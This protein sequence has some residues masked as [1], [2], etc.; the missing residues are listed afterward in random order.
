VGVSAVYIKNMNND[1]LTLEQH[2]Q[3]ECLCLLGYFAAQAG[4]AKR[5]DIIN[6]LADA[7]FAGK[8]PDLKNRKNWWTRKFGNI[9]F[10]WNANG[11]AGAMIHGYLM[12]VAAG[13]G[14]SGH[15]GVQRRI[16]GNSLRYFLEDL[17]KCVLLAQQFIDQGVS[18][19]PQI[20]E[21]LFGVVAGPGSITLSPQEQEDVDLA[22]KASPEGA[23]KLVKHYQR[24]RDAGLSRDAK[25]AFVKANGGKLFCQACGVEPL[26][27]YGV[28]VIEAHHRIPLSKSEEG[29]VT[30]ISDLIM[31]CPSCHRAVHRIPDC[32]FEFLKAKVNG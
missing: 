17:P 18:M 21:A 28:E 31:L 3:S 16:E 20:K 5:S 29:R 27:V 26:K 22:K 13:K 23:K 4:R 25:A 9:V 11:L 19:N 8:T 30:E 24:E 14:L 1:K 2:V 15:I 12:P 10:V 7:T 6:E 32:D